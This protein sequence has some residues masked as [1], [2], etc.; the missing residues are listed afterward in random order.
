[1]RSA[2]KLADSKAGLQ[3]QL[4]E[5]VIAPGEA[6]RRRARSAQ[7]SVRLGVSESRRLAVAHDAHRPQIT[8]DVV[9]QGAGDAGPAAQP[10]QRV[11]SAVNGGGAAADSEQVLAIGDQVVFAEALQRE[12]AILNAGVP[13]EKMA[14]VIA[15]AATR[16]RRDIGAR[17]LG[18]EGDQPGR[19]GRRRPRQRLYCTQCHPPS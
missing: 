16:R 1:M 19:V 11:E 5:R 7:K 10:A 3:H 8:R 17:Q 13:G 15:V 12:A 18:E 4:H 14:Q 9:T 2:A 6:V